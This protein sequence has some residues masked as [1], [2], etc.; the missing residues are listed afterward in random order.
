MKLIIRQYLASLKE[1]EELDAVL[2]DLLSQLGLN[3]YSTPGRGTRQDGV[4]VGAVGKLNGDTEE[5][6][7]LFS[8]KAGDLTRN[9]WDGDALQS[10]RPSLNEILDSYIPNRLPPEHKGKKIVICLCFGGV[11]KEQ[12]RP[13]VTGFID[14]VKNENVNFEEWNG[15]KLAELIQASFLREELL[16]DSARSHLRKAL[17]LIDEPEASYRYFLDLLHC[18]LDSNSGKDKDR[19]T[20]LRQINICL[21]I[22]FAW[23]RD[24]GNIESSYLCSELALLYGWEIAKGYVQKKTKV[25][26]AIQA[27]FLSIVG[28][29]QQVC[30][31]FLDEKVLP[32]VDKRHVLSV[33]VR[34]SCDL[35]I[36]L[37]LFD[38]LGRLALCGLW[39]YSIIQRI[40]EDETELRET[41]VESFQRYVLSI[42][43]LIENNPALKLPIKD[44]QAIDITLA[45]LLLMIDGNSNRDLSTWLREIMNRAL[46]ALKVHGKYPCNIDSYRDLLE[47]PT[48]D[49][50]YLKEN[51]CG[52]IL[53]PMIGLCAELIEDTALFEMVQAIK[54][55]KL[56]HCNFQLWFPDDDSEEHLY[57]NSDGHGAALSEIDIG[58]PLSEF[59][60][61]VFGECDHSKAFYQLSAQAPA[62][63]PLVLVACRHYRLPIPIH[64]FRD[65][66]PNITT[67]EVVDD[68]SQ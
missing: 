63:W 46:F 1:R 60:D 27:T 28:V 40:P 33:S 35:D 65:L 18:L 68:K 7:Y 2:P 19:L 49:D 24:A 56:E 66:R 10:L 67:E 42:K 64:P 37:R 22:H 14:Q 48:A 31:S 13:A 9:D 6:V 20:A 12:V 57:I 61:Q 29:Y 36:N 15:D 30:F 26:K 39:T 55:K 21:W 8:I 41:L 17:A 62:L 11:I 5:K 23:A 16:P 47:H 59:A 34:G 44:E 53:Y 32:F 43:Q 4:D 3:V 38:I 50:N 58:K 52:S 45:M 54:K 51:T 25:A